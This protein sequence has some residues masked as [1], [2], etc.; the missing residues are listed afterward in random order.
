MK[1][2]WKRNE[3]LGI[4]AQLVGERLDA[5]RDD[6]AG[7]ITPSAVVEDARPEGALLHPAF[8]WNDVAAAERWREEQARNLIRRIVVVPDADSK[9]KTPI[10]AYVNV[11]TEDGQGYTSV[12]AAMLDEILRKQVLQRAMDELTAWQKRYEDLEDFAAVF[13]AIETVREEVAA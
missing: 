3:S 1:Y 12:H 2:A 5:I 11:R 6:N 10:R 8:E 7:L 9:A 4:E 13:N